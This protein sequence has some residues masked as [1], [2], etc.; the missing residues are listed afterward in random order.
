MRHALDRCRP[1][2][3]GRPDAH[4]WRALLASTVGRL[5]DGLVLAAALDDFEGWVWF[6]P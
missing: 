2:S 1:K 3:H 5:R 4:T 6:C